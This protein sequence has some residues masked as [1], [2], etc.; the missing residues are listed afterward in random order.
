MLRAVLFLAVLLMPRPVAAQRESVTQLLDRSIARM[1]GDSALRAVQS[2]RMEMLT[3]WYRTSFGTAPFNDYPSPERNVELRNYATRSWRNSRYFSLTAANPGMVVIVHDTIAIRGNTPQ[4]ASAMAWAPLSVAYVEERRELFGYAPERLMLTLRDSR[5][6]RALADSTIDGE[7]HAR[8]ETTID[9]W[10]TVVFVRRSDALPRMVRFRADETNDMGLAPWA[11]HEVEFW[12][13][14]W[15][16][17][18][19]GVLLPRQRDV[20]RVGRPYKRMTVLQATINAPAPADSFAISDSLATA[21]FASEVRP[22]WRVVLEGV[23]KIE[24]EHFATFTPMTGSAG[25]VRVGNQ[26]VLLEAGQ[27]VGATELVAEWLGKHGGGSPIGGAIAANIW[28]GNG[29][30]PW[31]TSRRLPVYAAPGAMGTLRTVNKGVA[32]ITAIETPRWVRVGSDS[33]WLEPVSVPDFSRTLA[34]YSPTHRWLWLV[35]AGSPTHKMDQDAIVGRL[36]A[37]GM[38]VELVG[39]PRAMATARQ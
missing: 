21:Y 30:T 14:N 35:F 19:A 26:W 18:P 29:G 3:Q 22:M 8:L 10:P 23:A 32:G 11:L 31:F 24:R 1:G 20:Q 2:I 5:S 17:L 15:A 28:T 6:V 16:M 13:S 38:K 33:L 37:R 39:G 12:Y 34:V 7:V 9:G 36:E 4:G 27:A 25:A